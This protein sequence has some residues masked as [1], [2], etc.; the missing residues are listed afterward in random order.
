MFLAEARLELRAAGSPA[1]PR[2]GK[3]AATLCCAQE[4]GDEWSCRKEVRGLQ[5]AQQL[6]FFAG[7]EP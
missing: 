2:A 7:K 1:S 3:Q 4:R 5:G 6:F